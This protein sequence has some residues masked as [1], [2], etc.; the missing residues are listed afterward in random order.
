MHRTICATDIKVRIT[1]TLFYC[2]DRI[3]VHIITLFCRSQVH[4]LHN[5]AIHHFVVIQAAEWRAD[6]SDSRVADKI[7][8][9]EFAVAQ[10]ILAIFIINSAHTVLQ[11]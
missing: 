5:F 7:I 10:K 4:Q 6:D 11:R 2:P 9:D 1:E 3:I 8:S